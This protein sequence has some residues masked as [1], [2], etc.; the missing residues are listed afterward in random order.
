MTRF[1]MIAIA[2]METRKG[3]IASRAPHAD[4]V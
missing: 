2:I 3:R 1:L 4:G